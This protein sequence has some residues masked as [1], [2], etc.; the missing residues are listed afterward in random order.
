MKVLEL[1]SSRKLSKSG[2]ADVFQF[3]SSMFWISQEFDPIGG[4]Y[5]SGSSLLGGLLIPSVL[6]EE[7]FHTSKTSTRERKNKPTFMF[8]PLTIRLFKCTK[9]LIIQSSFSSIIAYLCPL[10]ERDDFTL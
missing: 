2:S 3:N 4:K 7:Q 6:D 8:D 5:I 1:E 10:K 9:G